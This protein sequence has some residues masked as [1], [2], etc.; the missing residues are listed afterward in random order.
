MSRVEFLLSLDRYKVFPRV[1]ELEDLEFDEA[2]NATSRSCPLCPKAVMH[3]NG[4]LAAIL[5]CQ[6]QMWREHSPL[7]QPSTQTRSNKIRSTNS[8]QETSLP[9]Q[10]QVCI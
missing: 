9:S 1:A 7:L 8:H 10:S 6:N 4:V 2:R 5:A 3:Q